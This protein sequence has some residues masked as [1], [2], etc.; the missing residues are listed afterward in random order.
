M[1]NYFDPKWECASREDLRARQSELLVQTVERVYQN[2]PYYRKKMDEAGVKPEHIHGL[3]DL[4]LLP[5]LTKDDLREAYPYG[6]MA[7]PLEDCVRIHSTS[8]TTGRRVVAFYTQNDVV[9]VH[10]RRRVR[11]RA[12]WCRSATVTA[13]S[14]AAPASTADLISSVPSRF[15]CPPATQTGR[16]SS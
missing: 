5:F 3:E 4:H 1:G 10:L 15:P 7:R 8:G 14:R 6:L 11:R 2:V 9:H 16:S 12:T 13:S